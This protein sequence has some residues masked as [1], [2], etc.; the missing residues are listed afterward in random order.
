M[1]LVIAKL[2]IARTAL[3]E[4]KTIQETKSILDIA[5]AA[6]TY[7]KRQKLGEEAICYATSIKIEALVQL[8]RMLK[9]TERAK[10]GQPYQHSTSTESVPVEPTLAD[11]GIDKKI[12]K[13]AQDL[14]ELPEEQLERVKSRTASLSQVQKDIRSEKI[15]A[16]RSEMATAGSKISQS[17]RWSVEVADINDYETEKRFDF[18]ITDPPYPKEYLPLYEV[19]A[20]RA[21]EWLQPDGLVIVMC[22]QSYVDDIYSMMSKHLSYYWTACY[23]T[24]GQPTPLRQRQVN[25]SWKPIL[26]YSL[27]TDYNG[28]I[29][30]DVF[31]SEKPDKDNHH[32]GQSVSGMLSILNQICLPG[33][34]I[35]DPFLGA[36]TTGVAALQFGCTFHGIDKDTES[37]NLSKSRLAE[38]N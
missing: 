35:F 26:I 17:D 18:I 30:G 28:K 6:E 4:A 25:T 22:G 32:W 11:L 3:V 9:D 5:V 34:S 36:G 31:T 38:I 19:L 20:I 8:G 21:K 37:V 14:L 29:F 16:V 27:S 10:G 7:A 33:Q 2:D 12:S 15:Q 23:L 13:L 1:D 24:P